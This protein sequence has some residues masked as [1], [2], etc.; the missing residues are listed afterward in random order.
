MN[1]GIINT[2]VKDYI[3]DIF[4]ALE[5]A[6]VKHKL[7]K[8]KGSAKIPFINHPIK[9]SL[10]LLEKLK[11]PPKEVIIAALLHDVLE[12]TNTLP[13]EI[14]ERFGT[15]V[16]RL[17]NEVTDDMSLSSKE[18][19]RKQIAKADTLTTE[20]RYIKI[21]DKTCNIRDI[22]TTKI[23]WTR[24]RKTNYIEWAIDVV[25]RIRDTHQGLIQEFYTSVRAAQEAL[26]YEFKFL[27]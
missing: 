6:S 16:L 10:L 7:Q 26:G 27:L 15:K 18:R 17:V 11:N 21:A 14:E 25:S 12:D 2:A 5:F 1:N 3:I 4:E 8:R 9:V 23:N 22:L 20:A 24:K 19:K 13:E